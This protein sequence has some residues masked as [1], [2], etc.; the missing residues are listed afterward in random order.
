MPEPT[1]PVRAAYFSMEIALAADIP[2]Y[3]GGLGVLAGDTLR[4]AADAAMPLAAVTLLYRKG[5]F[6][7]HLDAQGNQT[8]TPMAWNPEAVLEPK[9][10]RATIVIEG[11]KV[12]LRAW[13]FSVRGIG[14]S[15]VPVFLLD[16][17]LPENTEFDQTLTDHL[18]AG[19]THYRLCQE[20]VLGIGGMAMLNALGCKHLANYHMN[21]GHAALLTIALLES[22]MRRR[23]LKEVTPEELDSVK[24]KCIFTTHTPVPAGHDKFPRE[25]V[26]SVLGDARTELL[27]ELG[28]FTDG[29]LNMTYLGVRASNYING[30]AMRHAE[31]SR[32]M[33]PGYTIHAI[34][35][36][37][38]AATWAAP[39][40]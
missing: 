8:E 22:V 35:N 30:V 26:H 5:Y 2:T 18:Y 11:R 34:T 14:A 19:D 1:Q 27:D 33:F 4:S 3:A 23:P 20:V 32:T 10:A 37:V 17:A 25:L 15:I 24:R 21:E 31:I 40:F 9:D 38:H 16:S 29:I 12:V 39:A 28:S 7:Q 6:D 36:G 13:Q